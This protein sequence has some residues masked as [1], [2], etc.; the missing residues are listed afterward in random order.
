MS[1]NE[2][3][4]SMQNADS[5]ERSG[6]FIKIVE[7]YKFKSILKFLEAYIKMEKIIKFG[8]IEIQKQKFHQHKE[9]ISIKYIDINKIVV[10]NNVSFSKKGFKYFIGYKDAKKIRPLCIFLPKVSAYRKDFDETKC[11][12][13]LIKDDELLERYNEIWDKVKNIVKKESFSEQLYNEK[14]LKAKLKSFNGKI[15]TSFHNEFCISVIL[16]DFVFRIAKNYYPQVFLEVCKYVVKEKEISKY[17][18]LYY[19]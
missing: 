8:D 15:N 2:A 6:K 10:S 18:I 1:K 5:T 14:Y 7:N 3:M 11:M 19:F 9:P 17:I 13:F 16:S 12:S 4:K